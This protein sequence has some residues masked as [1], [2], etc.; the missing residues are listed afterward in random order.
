MIRLACNQDPIALGIVLPDG[1][2]YFH[3]KF[4]R[5]VEECPVCGE[6]LRAIEASTSTAIGD[7]LSASEA[8]DYLGCDTSWIRKLRA[9]GQLPAEKH[10]RDWYY[11]LADL[12]PFVGKTKG[13]PRKGKPS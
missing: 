4:R 5:H 6:F 7:L 2:G 10:G 13:R 1:S 12:E 3:E 8:A 9:S 11:R